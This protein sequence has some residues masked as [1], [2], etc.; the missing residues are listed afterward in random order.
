MDKFMKELEKSKATDLPIYHELQ[1][2]MAEIEKD[3]IYLRVSQ[4]FIRYLIEKHSEIFIDLNEFGW[5][6]QDLRHL[7]ILHM[8]LAS[9]DEQPYAD[10]AIVMSAVWSFFNAFIHVNKDAAFEFTKLKDDKARQ[11]AVLYVSNFIPPH[12]SNL[13]KFVN[14][15]ENFGEFLKGVEQYTDDWESTLKQAITIAR[16]RI[17][18]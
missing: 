13:D 7:W 16:G 2:Y 12:I 15:C 1:S 3:S 8:L 10:E 4:S 9:L 11:K 18:K 17:P 14:V 6:P 5:S